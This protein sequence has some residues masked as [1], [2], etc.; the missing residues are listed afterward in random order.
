MEENNVT[1]QVVEELAGEAPQK[2]GAN[3]L[4][5]VKEFLL[6]N[7]DELLF[8]A[9]LTLVAIVCVK[10]IMNDLEPQDCRCRKCRKKRKKRK[11]R[12]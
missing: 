9:Q 4:E 10:G 7:K 5:K 3:A 1:E 11:R 6:K 8:A 2:G 12:K